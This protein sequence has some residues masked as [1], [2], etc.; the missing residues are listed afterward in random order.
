MDFALSNWPHLHRVYWVTVCR[1]LTTAVSLFT[2]IGS[3]DK[4]L[5]INGSDNAEESGDYYD[6][7]KFCSG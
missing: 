3:G 5:G 7:G 1:V 6:N 4:Q 2:Y